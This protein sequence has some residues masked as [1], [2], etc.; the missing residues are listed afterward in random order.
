[1]MNRGVA[2]WRKGAVVSAVAAT[3]CYWI[4]TSARAW[5]A[6]ISDANP[7]ELFAGSLESLLATIAGV[8]SMPMLLW[9]GMR[10]FRERGNHLL[11]MVG[12][13]LWLY[14]GGHLVEDHVS[15]GGT[16]VFLAFFVLLSSLLALVKAQS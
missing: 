12:A 6:G 9:A 14:T 4:W 7:D 1:M 15:V 8:A 16:A 13:V 2:R 3:I 10:A 11:V 5:A